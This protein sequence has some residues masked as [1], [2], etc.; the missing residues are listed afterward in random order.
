[1][2]SVSATP[3]QVCRWPMCY[4][5][6]SR[7]LLSSWLRIAASVAIFG[8]LGM[9]AVLTRKGARAVA[10]TLRRSKS[11]RVQRFVRSLTTPVSAHHSVQALEEDHQF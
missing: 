4:L 11:A 10:D 8:L 6:R 1:M 2:R 3:L 7:T 9:I 5:H